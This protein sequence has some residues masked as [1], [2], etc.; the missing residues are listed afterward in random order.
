MALRNRL[1]GAIFVLVL[2]ACDDGYYYYEEEPVDYFSTYEG[3]P[4]FE[5][6]S[7]VSDED[8]FFS[9]S[10]EQS[11]SQSTFPNAPIAQSPNGRF[12]VCNRAGSQAV[13]AVNLKAQKAVQEVRRQNPPPHI[14]NAHMT[15]IRNAH[16]QGMSDARRAFDGCV[17]GFRRPQEVVDIA[18]LG[19]SRVMERAGIPEGRVRIDA[20][21]IASGRPLGGDDA[22]IPRAREQ[23][24]RGDRGTGANIARD[25]IRCITFARKC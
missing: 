17:A 1:I 3:Q 14:V 16:A 20:S 5:E 2:S 11:R 19:F 22:L 13:N 12:G 8:T 25:P 15:I 18:T 9:A 23:I 21:E 4:F 6:R 7:E 24:L 10:S